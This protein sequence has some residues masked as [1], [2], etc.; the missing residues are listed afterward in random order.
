M[1]PM[2]RI[3]YTFT[4]SLLLFG[5]QGCDDLFKAGSGKSPSESMEA[6]LDD[7]A[8]EHAQKHADPNYVCPM[9]PQIVRGEPGSCPIC[10][11]DLVQVEASGGGE[12]APSVTVNA[13]LAFNLGLKTTQ[14]ER[15]TLWKFIE[16]VGRIGYDED[17]VGH[18]HPYA[19]GWVKKLHVH[20]VGEP[21]KKGQVLLEYYAPE[22]LAAQEEYLVALG[23]AGSL[24]RAAKQRLLLLGVPKAVIDT[25]RKTRQPQSVTPILAPQDGVVTSLGLREGMYVNPGMELFTVADLASVWMLVDVFEHQLD[26]VSLGNPVD[27]RVGAIPGRVWSGKVEFIYPELDARTRSLKVRLRFDNSDGVLK[28]N[29]FADVTLYGGPH[30]NALSVPLQ[31][32]IRSGD[33]SRVV[34]K[35]GDDQYQPV[36]V[37]TG[38]ANGGRV[39]ILNGLEEGDEI[40]SSAQFMIDSESNLQASFQR[41]AADATSASSTAK[42]APDDS[43]KGE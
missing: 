8:V 18:V 25:L 13:G 20:S 2:I 5:L 19:K 29:M 17:H 7:S 3:L 38:M 37:V 10:G 30:R 34:K 24:R 21:V 43:A 16:T 6:V 15:G 9:H 27:I 28:P 40:V 1:K 4:F 14:A 22:I 41:F 12:G 39:E 11:M 31:A 32:V 33:A 35:V 42:A 23:G 36:E 26:W